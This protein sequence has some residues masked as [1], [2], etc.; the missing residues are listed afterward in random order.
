MGRA[1]LAALHRRDE[2]ALH[3]LGVTRHEFEIICWPEFPESRPITNITAE[4]AWLFSE[5]SSRSGVGRMTGLYGNRDLEFLTL[6]SAGSF[7]YRNF[8]R[9]HG[10]TIMARDRGTGEILRIKAAPSWIERHGRFKVLI[11]KD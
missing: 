10:M 7:P 4:D 2:A 6:E 3:A 11:F 5:A 8:V 1:I 9:H